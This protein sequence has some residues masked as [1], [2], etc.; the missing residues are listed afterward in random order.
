MG[1]EL[2]ATEGDKRFTIVGYGGQ[3]RIA[4]VFGPLEKARRFVDTAREEE[5]V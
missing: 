1:F 3:E 4:L 5:R 2:G